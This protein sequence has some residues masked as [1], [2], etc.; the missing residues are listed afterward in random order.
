[1]QSGDGVF[2]M[3]VERCLRQ[4]RIL[5]ILQH[6]TPLLFNNLVSHFDM[7]HR[8]SR[9]S[10]NSLLDQKASGKCPQ[11]ITGQALR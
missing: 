8:H 1:M 4:W 11:V 2:S 9:S 3:A 5:F 10:L 6:Y 7:S